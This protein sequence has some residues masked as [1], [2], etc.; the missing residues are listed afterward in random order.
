MAVR[1]VV[2]SAALLATTAVSATSPLWRAHAA[3]REALVRRSRSFA[4]SPVVRAPRPQAVSAGDGFVLQLPDFGGDPTGKNDSSAA[5]TAALQEAW[6]IGQA[7]G[8]NFTYGP[9]LGGVVIDLV[10]GQYLLSKPVTWPSQPGGNIV[11]QHGSLH[12]GPTFPLGRYLMELDA[13]APPNQQGGL[14]GT[15]TGYDDVTFRSVLFDGGLRAGGLKLLNVLRALVDGCYFLGYPAGSTGVWTS[16]AGGAAYIANSWFSGFDW[17]APECEDAAGLQQ[18]GPAIWLDFPDSM[19]DEVVIACSGGGVLDTSGANI[20][21]SVHVFGVRNV[22]GGGFLD[23]T[24]TRATRLIAPYV[25]FSR[26]FFAPGTMLS[27][28]SGFFLGCSEDKESS[29]VTHPWIVLNASSSSSASSSTASSLKAEARTV[30]VTGVSITGSQFNGHTCS[31]G[32]S[33]SLIDTRGLAS[34]DTLTLTDVVIDDNTFS[35]GTIAQTTR[36]RT[37]SFGLSAYT[38]QSNLSSVLAFPAA[39]GEGNSPFASLMWSLKQY[40]TDTFAQGMVTTQGPIVMATF[41]APING[42]LNLLA[43]QS[44]YSASP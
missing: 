32:V 4:G 13:I 28:E 25:D 27:I 20:L 18:V 10:G 6:R 30:A 23:A 9:D 34:Q 35:A 22:P 12:A 43:D 39:I 1:A 14:Q 5:F 37:S 40:A 33:P 21:R 44:A 17:P 8:Y 3:H 29:E 24:G 11:V 19:V 15:A 31:D 7:S 26:I 2:V 36:V 16:K 41:D 42:T 38:L